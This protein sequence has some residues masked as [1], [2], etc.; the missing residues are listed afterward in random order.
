MWCISRRF[1]F[2]LST[3]EQILTHLTCVSC[4]S[5]EPWTSR[6]QPFLKMSRGASH[7]NLRLAQQ[8]VINTYIWSCTSARFC[9]RWRVGSDSKSV[10]DN[11]SPE[12][13]CFAICK[14]R[15]VYSGQYEPISP[16]GK[17]LASMPEEQKFSFFHKCHMVLECVHTE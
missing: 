4:P 1:Q 11:T 5:G 3:C 2:V 10:I 16:K 9:E 7:F 6:S 17:R 14:L 8:Y 15:G 12:I 13:E